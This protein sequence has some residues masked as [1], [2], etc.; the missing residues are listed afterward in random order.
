MGLWSTGSSPADEEIIIIVNI[1]YCIV[2]GEC[3]L[4]FRITVN[5]QAGIF[6]YLVY[7]RETLLLLSDTLYSDEMI[8]LV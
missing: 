1:C 6:F 8:S 2:G 5:C 7:E 3:L 4:L